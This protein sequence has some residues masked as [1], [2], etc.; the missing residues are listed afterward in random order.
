MALTI[1]VD[2]TTWWNQRGFGRFTR[3]QLGAMLGEPR[4]H[5][6]ML[7]VDREPAEEMIRPNV[8]IVQVPTS[9]TVTELHR[10][11]R[12]PPNPGR[13]RVLARRVIA[14][15]RHLLVPGGLFVV[16]RASR[17]SRP[18]SPFTTPSRSI[19]RIS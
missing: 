14:A 13:A 6:L 16:S 17:N 5:R 3:G 15:A 2:A 4:G 18:S 8:E 19:L 9:A 1:G 11:R 10:R 7:F 12:K